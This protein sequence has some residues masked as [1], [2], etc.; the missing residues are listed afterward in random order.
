M[1]AAPLSTTSGAGSVANSAAWS[2]S[3]AVTDNAN[4]KRITMTVTSTNQILRGRRVLT[5][6]SL[7]MPG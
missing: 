3:G 2:L 1:L 5:V 6:T 4:L 7:K